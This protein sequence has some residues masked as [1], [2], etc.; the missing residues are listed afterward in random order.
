MAGGKSK[1]LAECP[2]R[3]GREK[4]GSVKKKDLIEEANAKGSSQ[5]SAER[6]QK[7]SDIGFK[8]MHLEMEHE[9]FYKQNFSKAVSRCRQIF[10]REFP[11]PAWKDLGI[12]WGR[13]FRADV[14]CPAKS[15]LLF[16]YRVEWHGINV[17]R[18]FRPQSEDDVIC[19]TWKLGAMLLAWHTP[20]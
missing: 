18:Q 19:E 4:G 2:A 11:R 14:F 3:A 5:E 12:I 9:D 7:I 1:N 8:K 6:I 10:Q 20:K 17:S 15:F 16:E 13:S